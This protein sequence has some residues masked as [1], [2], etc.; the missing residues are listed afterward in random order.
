MKYI[1]EFTGEWNES[2]ETTCYLF[3][4]HGFNIELLLEFKFIR[5]DVF[6]TIY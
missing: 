6:I 2:G 1:A 3:S 5:T 4:T